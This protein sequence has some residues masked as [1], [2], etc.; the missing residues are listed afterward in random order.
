MLEDEAFARP[1]KP[2]AP[3]ETLSIDEL[4]ARIARLQGEIARCEA[5]IAAKQNQKRAADAVFGAK[6]S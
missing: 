4:Q 3:F 2:E 6:S 5:A 1:P